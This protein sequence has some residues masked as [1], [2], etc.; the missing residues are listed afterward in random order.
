MYYSSFTNQVNKG[1]QS[2]NEFSA[3][4]ISNNYKVIP[5]TLN[6]NR[7]EHWDFMCINTEGVSATFDVKTG[8]SDDTCIIEVQNNFG[9]KGW[10][11]SE[12]TNFIAFNHCSSSNFI[13]IP[14]KKLRNIISQKTINTHVRA[15]KKPWFH[16]QLY[17]RK[18]SF[19]W[20]DQFFV[21]PMHDFIEEAII[22]RRK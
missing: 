19:G 10:S 22:I 7:Y 16:Y 20:N 14:L 2:E 4:M 12:T 21:M 1:Q 17:T 3:C 13:I 11:L 8:R 5:A 6:Q 15:S 9:Y 18:Y